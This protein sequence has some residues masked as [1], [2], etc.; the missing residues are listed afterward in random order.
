MRRLACALVR[1]YQLTLSPFWGRGCRFT[2][3]CSE[4]AHEA[5][6]RYGC[7]RGGWLALRRLLRCQPLCEHGYDPVP[8]ASDKGT[9]LIRLTRLTPPRF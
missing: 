2:P 1:G 7:L 5:I 6:T 4:Y 8:L 3:S 9:R